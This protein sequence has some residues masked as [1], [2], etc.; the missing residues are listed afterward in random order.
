LG[1]DFIVV[2][3]YVYVIYD[4]EGVINVIWVW[5]MM[6]M[7]VVIL[8]VVWM[9]LGNDVVDWISW[10]VYNFLGCCNGVVD[11]ECEVSFE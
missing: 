3:C 9:W 2:W 7:L 8:C 5:V 6:G 1:V 4:C 11:F 10:D